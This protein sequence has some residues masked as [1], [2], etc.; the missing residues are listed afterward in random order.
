MRKETNTINLGQK[1]W[2]KNTL[3]SQEAVDCDFVSG[4][5]NGVLVASST[6]LRRSHE[7]ASKASTQCWWDT[8]S[9]IAIQQ[10]TQLYSMR[11]TV[12]IRRAYFNILLATA[13]K[14]YSSI[15]I[16]TFL[17][18]NWSMCKLWI[19]GCS[20]GQGYS[21]VMWHK[22]KSDNYVVVILKFY[23]LATSDTRCFLNDDIAIPKGGFCR[24]LKVL[25]VSWL[26]GILF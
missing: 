18:S 16:T 26:V 15:L 17:W 3:G 10:V 19:P 13:R 2:Q 24:F 14:F 8:G 5:L 20:L 1:Y 23:L 12:I 6:V 7:R 22:K 9:L 11:Y 4:H 21:R 25:P